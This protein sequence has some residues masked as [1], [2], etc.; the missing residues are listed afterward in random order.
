MT[1]EVASARPPIAG[2]TGRRAGVRRRWLAAAVV[3]PLLAGCA[4]SFGAQTQRVYQPGPGITVRSSGVYVLNA[5]I[6][7]DSE[8][9][10]TLVAGLVNQMTRPDMLESVTLAGPGGKPLSAS[11]L[12][13]TV[14]LPGQQLVQLAD[15]GPVRFG[16]DLVGGV[17]YTLSL[18]FAS[19]AP[20]TVMIPA[21]TVGS[22]AEFSTVP[23][24]PTPSAPTTASPGS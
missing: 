9:N 12:P 14:A 24:G 1:T 10:G 23:V 11:I 3:A 18:G 21:L 20:V 5:F 6:V 19:A 2:P 7:T 4:T 17:N 15:S 16:G 13:G 22:G 8:G